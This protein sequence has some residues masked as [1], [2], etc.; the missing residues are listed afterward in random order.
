VS[1]TT[2]APADTLGATGAAARS[3]SRR[4]PV[5]LQRRTAVEHRLREVRGRLQRDELLV[6]RG[7]PGR[8]G[9]Q[10]HR[11]GVEVRAQRHLM[12]AK[13]QGSDDHERQPVVIK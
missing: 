3:R 4:P 10:V 2:W 1:A 11:V 5:G 12:T 8:L 9:V 7:E 13:W 6:L